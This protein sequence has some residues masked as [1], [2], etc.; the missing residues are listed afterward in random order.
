MSQ[1]NIHPSA[2]I[3]PKAEIDPTATIG[4][5]V[6]IEA[7]VKIGPGTTI[8]PYVHI[9]GHCEIGANNTIATGCTIAHPPQHTAY[10]GAPTWVRIGDNNVIREYVS[11]NR[12]YEEGHATVV[13]NN[14]FFMGF[15][16]VGH[17]CVVGN[18]VI[19]AN[20]A[21]LAGHVTVG[22]RSFISGN[23][24]IHQFCR[25]GRLVMAAGGSGIGQDVP[26]FMIAEGRPAFIRSLN[27]VGLSR[28]GFGPDKR[29]EVKRLYKALY[30]SGKTVKSA[31]AELD[32]STLGPECMELV[33]F[34]EK[35]KR[36][37]A[38][39]APYSR[40]RSAEGEE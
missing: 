11:I 35:S 1:P 39:F 14:C 17:D 10:R 3:D 20:G 22:D 29:L 12:G 19:I 27:T 7:N 9:Q 23:V 38:S 25:I 13:G 26:P 15:S 6:V 8:G 33:H 2:V 21:L 16:H 30:R 5:F 32:I 34:Y 18:G 37:V 36:G 28:A 31:L 24:V 40:G 4:P